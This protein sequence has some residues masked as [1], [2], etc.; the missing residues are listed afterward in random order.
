[1]SKKREARARKAQRAANRQQD[2]RN[3]GLVVFGGLVML[4][5]GV[6]LLWFVVVSIRRGYVHLDTG[7]DLVHAAED[8]AAFWITNVSTAAMGLFCAFMGMQGLLQMR[9]EARRTARPARRP[10]PPGTPRR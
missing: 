5:V 8:P 2:R 7:P 1:M 9:D 6:G 4:A 10:L 3:S